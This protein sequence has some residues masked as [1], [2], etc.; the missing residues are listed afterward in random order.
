MVFKATP[1]AKA[2]LALAKLTKHNLVIH[3]DVNQI[4]SL[5]INHLSWHKAFQLVLHAANLSYYS[6]DNTLFVGSVEAIAEYKKSHR[7]LMASSQVSEPML[8][9]NIKLVYTQAHALANMLFNGSTNSSARNTKHS[10]TVKDLPLS[11]VSFNEMVEFDSI[12]VD[13]RTNSLI[14]QATH[15]QLEK[16]LKLISSIDVP[17]PQVMIKADIVVTKESI[18]EEVGISWSK[19]T[20][21]LSYSV[22]RVNQSTQPIN[23]SLFI[24]YTKFDNGANNILSTTLSALEAEGRLKVIAQPKITASNGQTS[25][26]SSGTQIPYI[27]TTAD[28]I[29]TQFKEAV[30][31]LTVTPHITGNDNIMLDLAITQDAV[32]A[33]YGEIPSIDT[34]SI[35]TYV[36]AKNGETKVLGGLFTA[37]TVTTISQVPIL[38]DIPWLGWLFKTKST[39]IEK[40]ELLIFITPYIIAYN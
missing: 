39:Q 17:L 22:G 23:S 24:N 37:N 18:V 8:I 4:I 9:R 35:E 6:I 28:S 13:S 10:A 32:G 15:E 29:N 38:G 1:V 33:I 21:T 16:I 5:Q 11:T 27:V 20:D 36:L 30:L 40:V 34:N 25:N 19:N 12:V 7:Q 14:V 31:S 26:I 3:N 2:L